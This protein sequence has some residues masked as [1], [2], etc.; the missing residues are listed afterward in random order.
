MRIYFSFLLNGFFGSFIILLE[1]FLTKLIWP[2]ATLIRFPFSIRKIGKIQGGL[3]LLTG[4]GL[5]IDILDRKAELILGNNIKISY[6][7]HIAVI[8]K[9]FI[10]NNVLIAGNVFISDHT[11]GSYSGILHSHPDSAP[12]DRVL[13]SDGVHISDNCW[14]GRSVCILKGVSIGR[15][16]IIGANSVVNSSLPDYVIA[17]GSP[18]KILKTWDANTQKWLRN[19]NN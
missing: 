19:E 7:C 9:V 18:A 6:N 16:V 8:K 17:A 15:G 11:H 5:K 13:D 14:I 10:G 3:N 4:K 12:N 1:L 2:K